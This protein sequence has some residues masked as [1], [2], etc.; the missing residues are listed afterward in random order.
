MRACSLGLVVGVGCRALQLAAWRPRSR[1]ALAACPHLPWRKGSRRGG[2][3]CGD[4]RLVQE[5]DQRGGALA[6]AAVVEPQL[7]RDEGARGRQR[8]G[9]G[10]VE[11]RDAR[12]GSGRSAGA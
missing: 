3:V 2:R 6:R 8:A 4:G 9:A 12:R 10:G 7:A 5:A 11:R 1:P